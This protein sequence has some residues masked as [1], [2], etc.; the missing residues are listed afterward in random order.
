M[1]IIHSVPRTYGD[2]LNSAGIKKTNMEKDEIP[3]FLPPI[4]I[5]RFSSYRPG[6]KFLVLGAVHGNEI[7]GPIAIRKIIEEIRSGLIKL[8]RGTVS[9]IPIVNQK[10]YRQNTREGDR[11]LNRNL[12]EAAIARDNEDRIANILCPVLKDHD[13]LLDI[14]SFKSEGIPFVFAGPDNNEG[15]LEPFSLADEEL[16]LAGSLGV[17]LVM[18]GWLESY[19]SGYPSHPFHGVGTTEYMRYA[20]GYAVTL[21]CGNH[22]APSA[23]DIAYKAIR[24]ALAHLS[25]IN[26]DKPESVLRRHVQMKQVFLAE[27]DG[28]RLNGSWQTFDPV[29]KDSVIAIRATGEELKAPFDGLIIFPNIQAKKGESLFYLAE[30]TER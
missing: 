5:I 4:E 12:Q 14:H 24:N 21:E 13:V 7:C 26:A 15:T 2:E 18:R 28:D 22:S 16:A 3:G 29:K 19:A 30:E 10:A 27:Q 11:N 1:S 23:P 20:G 6:P 9:F 25:M 17:D 8:Q